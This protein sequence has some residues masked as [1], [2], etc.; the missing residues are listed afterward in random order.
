MDEITA[1]LRDLPKVPITCQGGLY[2]WPMSF[3]DDARRPFQPHFPL[4]ADAEAGKVHPGAPFGPDEEPWPAAVRAL[5]GFVEK[6]LKNKACPERVEVRD[7]ELA[8]YLRFRLS[9]TGIEVVESKTLTMADRAVDEMRNLLE[10]LAPELPGWLES[11][12]MTVERLRAFADA[13]AEF[14]R[15]APWLMLSD[16]DLVVVESPKPPKGMACFTVLGAGRQTYG[17]GI[18]A[19]QRHFERFVRAGHTGD[20]DPS[21][22]DGFTQFTFE[23]REDLPPAEVAFWDEHGL[24]VAAHETYPDVTKRNRD[25]SLTRPSV[26]ELTY[27]EAVLRAFAST[28]EEEVDSGRWT[29]SVVTFDGPQDIALAIPDL[30][31]PPSAA[32]WI[33]RGFIPDPRAHERAFADLDRYLADHPAKSAADLKSIFTQFLGRAFD[34]PVTQPSNPA[35]RAQ[36]VCYQAA[37]VHGRRRIQLARD[38]LRIDPDCADAYVL[39]AESAPLA[40]RAIEFYQQAIAAAERKLG[41]DVFANDVGNFWMITA[42]RPYMRAHFGLAET[43][44][45][46]GRNAEAIEHFSELLRLNPNDNQGARYSLLPMLLENGQDQQAARLLKRYDEESAIWQYARALLAFQLS[47]TSPTAD[48]E[49]RRAFQLNSHVPQ[50]IAA[51]EKF[52]L[53][54]TFSPG[55]Y[56]EACI[57]V[58]ALHDAYLATAGAI[59]W[60]LTVETKRAAEAERAEREKRRKQRAKAKK[61]RKR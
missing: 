10:R 4:W 21:L 1:K 36:E 31:D 27:L 58:D 32:E 47:G 17:L 59:D 3:L 51:H 15:A 56:E 6:L 18:Y 37:E 20:L 30:L 45:E 53:P 39:L 33:K 12:G 22:L 13:A 38:A 11:Q 7:P 9:G 41:P 34:D 26:K 60:M 42:T 61:K 43:L 25:G 46:L 23:E 57:A 2:T 24:P 48:R 49:L 50:L 5:A 44:A 54:P 29:K 52:P 35:D 19:D 8:Q 28:A 40:E 55:S 16:C 14:Y